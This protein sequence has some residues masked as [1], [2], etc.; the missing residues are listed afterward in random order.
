M[1]DRLVEILLLV[2]LAVVGLFVL[3]AVVDWALPDVYPLGRWAD[4]AL[5]LVTIVAILVGG[6]FAAVKFDLFR[7][8]QPHLTISHTIN[9]RNIADSYVHLDVTA[10]LHNSSRVKVELNRGLFTLQEIAPVLDDAELEDRLEA[11]NLIAENLPFSQWA[12]L[13]QFSCE[14]SASTL[15]IEPGQ[16]FRQTVEFVISREITT[17]AIHAFFYNSRFAEGFERPEGWNITTVYDIF[18]P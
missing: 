5:T 2:L 14:W 16:T 1:Q 3:I 7:E 13:D 12:I 18:T 11:R 4:I 6:L 9:H 10:V 8:S 15:V 17:V